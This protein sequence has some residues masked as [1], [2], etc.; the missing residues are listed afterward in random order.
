MGV[1]IIRITEENYRKAIID[2]HVVNGQLPLYRTGL[3]DKYDLLHEPL[4]SDPCCVQ[5]LRVGLL[6]TNEE[7]W[8]MVEKEEELPCES[9]EN[10]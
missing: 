3:N 4:D 8:V 7:H 9:T 1:T 5:L 2:E 10:S 6:C